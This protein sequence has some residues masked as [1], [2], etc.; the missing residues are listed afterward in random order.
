M[1][2]DTP[3]APLEQPMPDYRPDVTKALLAGGWTRTD[4]EGELQNGDT[5]WRATTQ[6]GDS[7]IRRGPE[8]IAEFESRCPVIVIVA[9][10]LAAAGQP[11]E[12]LADVIPLRPAGARQ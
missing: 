12:Q 2:V 10:C 9:A 11:V 3:P 6:P 7:A 8:W 5:F 1:T 4:R